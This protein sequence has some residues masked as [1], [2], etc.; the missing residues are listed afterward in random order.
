MFSPGSGLYNLSYTA[1]RAA[2]AAFITADNP[3]EAVLIY[4]STFYYE[5][6]LE[7]AAVSAA[8]ISGRRGKEKGKEKN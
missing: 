4:A 6:E 5:G 2:S 3:L 1:S 8:D 7:H